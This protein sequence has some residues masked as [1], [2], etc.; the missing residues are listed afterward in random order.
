MTKI[1]EF[2]LCTAFRRRLS[3]VLSITGLV[4]WLSGYPLFG[5]MIALPGIIVAS[6]F[7]LLILGGIGIN[8]MGPFRW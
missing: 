4:V 5:A 8:F 6:Y 3:L 7:L 1:A 2:F